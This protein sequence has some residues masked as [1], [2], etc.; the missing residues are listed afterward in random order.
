MPPMTRSICFP[1][2]YFL[3]KDELSLRERFRYELLPLLDE[4]LRQGFLGPA[5]TELFAVRDA[6][7]DE[8]EMNGKN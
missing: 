3:A 1:D 6:I 8:T 2:A 4:Y 5:S 7:Q